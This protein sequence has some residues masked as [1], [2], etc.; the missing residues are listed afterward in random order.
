MNRQPRLFPHLAHGGLREALPRVDMTPW[1]GPERPPTGPHGPHVAPWLD[2]G[3]RHP[4]IRRDAIL[5]GKPLPGVEGHAGGEVDDGVDVSPVDV[6]DLGAAD[7]RH[8]GDG[9]HLAVQRGRTVEGQ[10]GEPAQI[11]GRRATRR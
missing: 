10:I 6:G 5:A 8:P 9:E 4:G 11:L 2:D 1:E 3:D 7:V